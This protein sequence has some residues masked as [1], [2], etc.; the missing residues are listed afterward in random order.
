MVTTESNALMSEIHSFKKRMPVILRKEDE[1][2]WLEHYQ[3]KNL[4]SLTR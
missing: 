3:L 4:L 1:N 2:I